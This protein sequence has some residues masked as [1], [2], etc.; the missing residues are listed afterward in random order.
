MQKL[1]ESNLH[2]DELELILLKYIKFLH[3]AFIPLKYKIF[4]ILFSV[5]AQSRLSSIAVLSLL[6]SVAVLAL[7]AVPSAYAA[8]LTVNAGWCSGSGFSWD[9]GTSTCTLTTF[10]EV[11]AGN[12]LQIPSGTTLTISGA[13]GDIT[14]DT[15]AGL[16]LTAAASSLSKSAA[17]EEEHRISASPTTVPSPTMA[18]RPSTS[19]PIK[20]ASSTR[21]SSTTTAPS[22]SRTVVPSP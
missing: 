18:P 21:M 17:Q 3:P 22:T 16:M 15:G 8:T 13:A 5:K 10:Y 19:E 1:E 11:T 4:W 14:V 6:A 20:P 9:S 12:T 7:G 2:A